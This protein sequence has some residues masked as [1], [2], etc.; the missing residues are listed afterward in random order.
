MLICLRVNLGSGEAAVGQT[1]H[2]GHNGWV[3]DYS[4]CLTLFG[5]MMFQRLWTSCKQSRRR[6]SKKK[7]D[8]GLL[9]YRIQDLISHLFRMLWHMENALRP[10]I[11]DFVR[12]MNTDPGNNEENWVKTGLELS[13]RLSIWVMVAKHC[14]FT[15]CF[16]R[17][18]LTCPLRQSTSLDTRQGGCDLF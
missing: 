13:V 1:K 17:G 11:D 12:H 14:A 16:I 3:I 7:T 2:M 18:L 15:N 6:N 5:E 4:E 10:A 8:L 9:G